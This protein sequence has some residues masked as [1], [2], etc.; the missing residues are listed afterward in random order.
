VPDQVDPLR[1]VV[2]G[3]GAVGS[4]LGGMLAVAGHDVA[5]LGR[6]IPEGS[7]PSR[8]VIW[9]PEEEPLVVSVRRIT[10][11]RSTHEPDLVLLAV[12]MFDLAGALET[13]ARWPDSPLMTVQNGAGAEEMAQAA[14]RSPILAGSLTTAVEPAT[15]GVRRLRTGGM[16]VA[17]VD[18][19]QTVAG[20][21]ALAA[22]LADDWTAAG[23]PTRVY[24][25]AAEMKW[26][27]LLGNLVGNATSAILD[28]DPGAVY[29]DRDGYH[30]ERTQIREVVAVMRAMGLRPVGLPGAHVSALL[31][32]LALP[33]AI[34][35]PI[36]ARAVAGARGGKL[37]SLRLHVRGGG[38]GS[39]IAPAGGPTEAR[40]LNGAVA[41]AGA[42]LGVPAPCNAELARLVDACATDPGSAAFFAGRPDRLAA[43]VAAPGQRP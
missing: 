14:R 42:R 41:E 6:R 26:S 33:E 37:P 34:G 12:K 7:D 24:G 13:A 22:R 2:V 10:D 43:A 23:L 18:E 31:A 27:K 19:G 29:A 5:L 40:W 4:F 3:P 16:G 30:V 32:G 25:N 35:R 15:G 8:L 21:Q 9:E 20:A 36:V 1:V 38:E 17:V 39:G 28:M 11:P